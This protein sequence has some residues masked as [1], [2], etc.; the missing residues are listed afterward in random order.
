MFIEKIHIESFGKLENVSFEFTKSLNV[1]YALNDTG[2]TTLLD[3][4]RFMFYGSNIKK[5]KNSLTFKQ[6]YMPWSAS[7]MSGSIILSDNDKKYYIHRTE[8]SKSSNKILE[9]KDFVTGESVTDISDLGKYFFGV[10]EKDFS[11]TFFVKDITSLASSDEGLSVSVFKGNDD[12]SYTKVKNILEEKIASISS[13]KR[14]NSS[15]KIIDTN[16]D[17]VNNAIKNIDT[18]ISL[19]DENVLKYREYEEELEL[20]TEFLFKLK[21][22]KTLNQNIHI[23]NR[24]NYL[25]SLINDNNTTSNKILSNIS[26]ILCSLFFITSLFFATTKLIYGF[27]LSLVLLVVSL[28]VYALSGRKLITDNK[29]KNFITDEIKSLENKIIPTSDTMQL[30]NIFTNENIDDIISKTESEIMFIKDNMLVLETKISK[31]DDL[32]LRKSNLTDK[33]HRLLKEKETILYSLKVYETALEILKKSFSRLEQDYMPHI[34]QT[35]FEIFRN[36]YPNKYTSIMSNDKFEAMIEY[37][38]FIKDVKSLSSATK[39]LVYLSFRLSLCQFI[40]NGDDAPMFFDDV[41]L[42]C[43]DIK[44]EKMMDYFCFI[45]LKRQIFASICQKHE[46]EYYKSKDNVNIIYL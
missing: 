43:D 12:V 36:F 16:L 13:T 40:K 21:N 8:N 17:D 9:V 41:L 31:S 34:S 38:N 7:N 27:V 28:I 37:N 24:I 42:S 10:N 39:D 35:A 11:S 32:K 44:S 15:L 33:Y 2:K 26:L 1:I 6:Q 19:N 30:T 18:E 4:I 3:F 5:E 14:N 22:D 25:K 45:S 46:L 23:N 20:K 29:T